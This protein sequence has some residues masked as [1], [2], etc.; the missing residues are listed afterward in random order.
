MNLRFIEAFVWV[1]RL[2]SF[3]AAADKLHMTQAAISSRIAAL[4]NQLGMRL[5][6]RDE[7][8]VALTIREA[9]YLN[10]PNNCSWHTRE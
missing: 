8:N 4:E 9:N 5:F 10:T 3:K 2:H 1:A 6:E 7:R